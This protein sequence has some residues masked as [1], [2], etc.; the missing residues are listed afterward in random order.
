[1]SANVNDDRLIFRSHGF[2]AKA[3]NTRGCK[4]TYAGIRQLKDDDNPSS[5][6]R[7]NEKLHVA[8]Y[9]IGIANFPGPAIVAWRSLDGEDHRAAIDIATIF[10]DQRILHEVAYDDIAP[11]IYIGDPHIVLVV[12]DRTITVYMQAHIPLKS[13]RIHGNRFSDHASDFIVAYQK[14]Y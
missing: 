2:A 11:L 7:G 8:G 13:P 4:V 9:H 6:R 3:F 14:T 1:M 10:H 12:D 5:P